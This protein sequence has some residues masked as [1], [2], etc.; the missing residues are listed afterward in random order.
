MCRQGNN[1]SNPSNTMNNQGN[2]GAQKENEKSPE[3]K[4][5]VME[6]CDLNDREFNIAV[7]N[8]LSEI[9]ENSERQFNE[10]RK[11]TNE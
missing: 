11:K 8:K 7:S 6:D 1:L 10:H 4:L 5:Q 2:I 3:A 9:Q